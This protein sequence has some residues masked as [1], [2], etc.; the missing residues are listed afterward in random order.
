MEVVT[1]ETTRGRDPSNNLEVDAD[2]AVEDVGDRAGQ[3]NT[4]EGEL[5]RIPLSFST[6]ARDKESQ[7]VA[8]QFVEGYLAS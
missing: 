4:G 8:T 3:P 7:A 6:V 5:N 2:D 1:C